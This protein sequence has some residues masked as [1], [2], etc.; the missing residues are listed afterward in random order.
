MT[1]SVV[2]FIS[3]YDSSGNILGSPAVQANVFDG[4]ITVGSQSFYTT[5]MEAIQ[6]AFAN[7]RAGTDVSTNAQTLL[8]NLNALNAWAGLITANLSTGSQSDPIWN[9]TT[10][11]GL[12]PNAFTPSSYTV[13]G[14]PITT[15][16]TQL[17]TTMS[18]YMAQSLEQ[19]NRLLRSVGFDPDQFLNP[20]TA[21]LTQLITSLTTLTAINP[22]AASGAADTTVYQLPTLIAKALSAS[23]QARIIDNTSTQSKSIQEALA[24][25]YISDGNQLIFDR[26]E[27]LNAAINQNQNILQ[28]LNAIQDLA[29]RKDPQQF[30]LKLTEISNI[31][32]TGITDTQY[33]NFENNSFN[34]Q[35]G[36]VARFTGNNASTLADANTLFKSAF[37]NINSLGEVTDP[38]VFN[39][40][41]DT[42]INN[43]TSLVTALL[44]TG[45]TS[46]SGLVT[47]LNQIKTDLTAAT[48]LEAWV[49]DFQ[50]NATTNGNNQQNLNNAVTAAQSFNQTQQSQLQ[51][52]MFVFQQFYQSASGLLSSIDRVLKDIASGINK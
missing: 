11:G 28:F 48:S 47:A 50:P 26:M 25:D 3:T 1:Q 17:T 7:I 35:L 2:P 27:R 39:Y 19:I 10:P 21:N 49:E 8:N 15:L 5:A 33:A 40:A 9:S 44:N 12:T 18:N 43:I 41:K 20:A 38:N 37:N 52:A 36:T 45:T 31:N 30:A 46:G 22:N 16:N 29:N 23:V 13:G 34:Q 4:Q 6:A 42:L 32:G 14:H 51:Q 24:V